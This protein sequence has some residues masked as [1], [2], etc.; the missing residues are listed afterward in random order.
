MAWCI[1]FVVCVLFVSCVYV[2]VQW[3]EETARTYFAVFGIV[4][5]LE[6]LRN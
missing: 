1:I 5:R 4:R 6:N 3:D 2:F